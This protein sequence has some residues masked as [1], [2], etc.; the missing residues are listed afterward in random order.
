MG[1]DKQGEPKWKYI[2]EDE[3]YLWEKERIRCTCQLLVC[4]QGKTKTMDGNLREKD[5][6]CDSVYMK[7]VM[8]K[9]GKVRTKTYLK[10]H[11]PRG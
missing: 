11:R 10:H 9:V 2:A 1:V 4:Y 5:I 6:N 3:E 8:P 7:N